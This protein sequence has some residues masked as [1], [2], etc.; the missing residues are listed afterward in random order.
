MAGK[1]CFLHGFKVK[2]R[3]D[4]PGNGAVLS[5]TIS[6]SAF[7]P[8]VIKTKLRQRTKEIPMMD[9]RYLL[10]IFTKKTFSMKL[11]TL[12]IAFVCTAYSL[13]GQVSI[14]PNLGLNI[15]SQHFSS[16]LEDV[17]PALRYYVGVQA[18]NSMSEKWAAGL[19]L[20]LIA[21]GYTKEGNNLN[22]L[23]SATLSYL[24]AA[25][26]VE[27]KPTAKVGILLGGAIGF[28]LAEN[29]DIIGARDRPILNL[30][31]PLDLS[32]MAGLKYY[33]R[34][35][36]LCATFSHSFVSIS[37]ITYTDENGNPDGESKIYNQGLQIGVGY[38]FD[39]KKG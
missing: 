34:Q 20:Q 19:G 10:H 36:F 27:F 5:E 14:L 28:S 13:V 35:F 12:L 3:A 31:D 39:L 38:Q 9:A 6:L 33:F 37:D 16:N 24:E 29:Y 17:N 11:R 1:R 32:G 8:V 2:Q 26:F 15:S 4:F 7:C 23:T 25:P 22:D 21:K 30:Y 18:K